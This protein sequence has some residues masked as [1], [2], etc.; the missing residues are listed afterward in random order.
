MFIECL[1]C[2]MQSAERLASFHI[3]ARQPYGVGNIITPILQM[4]AL[5][6]PAQDHTT[7]KRRR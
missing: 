7:G 5:R 3:I 2:A 1:A 4:E 6:L